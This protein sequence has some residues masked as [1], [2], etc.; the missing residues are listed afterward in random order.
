MAKLTY[1]NEKLT[2]NS[3][4]EVISQITDTIHKF[5]DEPNYVKLYLDTVLYISDLPKGYNSI[6]LAF[7]NHMS[8][9]SVKNK[10]NGQ[11]IYVNSAM[12]KGIAEDLGVTI[13]RINHAITD[14]VKGKVFYRVDRGTYQV[15]PYLFGKGDW[16]DI[17]EIRMNITFNAQG[18]TVMS[19][20][21]HKKEIQK[22]TETILRN[23]TE[24]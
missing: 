6:L 3:D 13:D 8:Y 22:E 20:I 10:E 11:L 4:G 1:R 19:E 15:N 24:G 21:E 23:G 14:F 7:L 9:A 5:E 17:K 16:K 12:K 18:K 2:T